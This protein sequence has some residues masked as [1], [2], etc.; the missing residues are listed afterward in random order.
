MQDRPG[1]SPAAD[2]PGEHHGQAQGVAAIAATAQAQRP[3]AQPRQ[4]VDQHRRAGGAPVHV[5]AVGADPSAAAGADAGDGDVFELT[6]DTADVDAIARRVQQTA[7]RPSQ[8]EGEKREDGGY[9]LL[10][11]LA[12]L[13]LHSFRRGWVVDTE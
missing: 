13:S 10:V 7:R 2:Q 4:Q 5:L 6:A 11:P 1:V 9:W 8:G 3:Q 12:L